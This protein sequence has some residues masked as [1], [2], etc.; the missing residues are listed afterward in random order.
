MFVRKRHDWLP[1]RILGLGAEWRP[2][3]ETRFQKHQRRQVLEGGFRSTAVFARAVLSSSVWLRALL[4]DAVETPW[5]V[6]YRGHL[7]A[8]RFHQKEAVA[9]TRLLP[10]PEEAHTRGSWSALSLGAGQPWALMEGLLPGPPPAMSGLQVI[11]GPKEEDIIV[12]LCRRQ[13][14]GLV[15][16]PSCT[17]PACPGRTAGDVMSCSTRTCSSRQHEGGASEPALRHGAGGWRPRGVGSAS[18]VTVAVLLLRPRRFF[19]RKASAEAQCIWWRAC[20]TVR[21]RF[22]TASLPSCD[23][24]YADLQRP[25]AP[26]C[27]ERT[28][29]PEVFC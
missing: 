5:R 14:S 26:A 29:H 9:G 16:T 15:L 23:T 27:E 19:S 20:F 13:R 17:Q 28:Q 22:S 10:G 4:A 21:H 1:F 3:E 2:T 25:D 12:R 11:M 8:Q 24:Q 7:P 18:R 6:L